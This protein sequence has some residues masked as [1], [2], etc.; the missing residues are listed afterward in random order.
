MSG[1]RRSPTRRP[2]PVRAPPGPRFPAGGRDRDGQALRGRALDDQALSEGNGGPGDSRRAARRVP[3][4]EQPRPLTRGRLSE[5]H[6]ASDGHVSDDPAGAPESEIAPL[7]DLGPARQRRPVRCG[8]FWSASAS[9][10]AILFWRCWPFTSAT[11]VFFCLA[12]WNIVETENSIPIPR[13]GL[14][15]RAV[16][17][18]ILV[19]LK[20]ASEKSALARSAPPSVARVKSAPI[21]RAN[22]RSASS[23]EASVKFVPTRSV[24]ERSASR[25]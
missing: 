14:T 18:Q 9:R 2:P 19:P 1:A 17:P 21:A 5:G 3:G 6:R 12:L 20:I 7:R 8:G 16:A 11:F 23:S 15:R 22:R 10:A 4:R 25:A 13:G 24:P